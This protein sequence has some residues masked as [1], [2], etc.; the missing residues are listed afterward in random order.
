MA[1]AKRKCSKSSP[2]RR[3]DGELIEA[4]GELQKLDLGLQELHQKFGDDADSRDDYLAMCDRRFRT[5]EVLAAVP[6]KSTADIAAKAE[7]LLE[8][9]VQEAYDHAVKI[10]ASLAHDVCL[11]AGGEAFEPTDTGRRQAYELTNDELWDCIVSGSREASDQLIR[12][13]LH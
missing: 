5:L 3:L 1:Q 6:A 7:V 10:G 13:V 2:T 11:T 4:C 9:S 12:A 8:R